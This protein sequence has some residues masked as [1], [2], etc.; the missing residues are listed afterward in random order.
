[1]GFMDSSEEAQMVAGGSIW[2]ASVGLAGQ[3]AASRQSGG[4]GWTVV[5]DV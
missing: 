4:I 5:D 2:M 3:E 1:M